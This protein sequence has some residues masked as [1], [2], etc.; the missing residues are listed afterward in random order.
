MANLVKRSNGD[1]QNTAMTQPRDLDPVRLVREFLRWDPFREM[2]PYATVDRNL[3]T[4][5]FEV[6]EHKDRFVFKADMPGV[7][8][9]NLDIKI[10][11][12]RLQIS[13][14]RENEHEDRADS[15]YACERSYGEFTRVFTLPPD[16]ADLDHVQAELKHGVLQIVVPKKQGSQTKTIQLKA[17]KP[18]S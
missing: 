18:K 2:L 17:D 5:A 13:G 8:E 15:Y 11:G 3:F 4:P 9:D 12:N 10:T 14:K 16:Q 7:P 6:A 1:D